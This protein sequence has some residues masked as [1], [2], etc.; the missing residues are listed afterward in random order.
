MSKIPLSLGG[1]DAGASGNADAGF[2][3][4]AGAQ[5]AQPKS[6]VMGWC[7][8]GFGLL[9]IFTIGFVFVP[10]GLICSIAALLMRQAV[11]GVVGILLAVAGFIVSP[12]L[13]LIFG[14]GAFYAWFDM[15][16]WLKPIYE[17]LNSIGIGGGG[18][19]KQ[20]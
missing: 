1:D 20:V 16:A 8:V 12:K 17:F 15:D 4:A 7:A 10:L 19:T 13:W 2:D 14:I 5:R 11:W 18:E 9:G 6:P 3:A